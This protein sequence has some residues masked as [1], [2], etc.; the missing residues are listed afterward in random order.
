MIGS[1]ETWDPAR[2]LG[3]I[4]GD[5]GKAYRA[6]YKAFEEYQLRKK[7]ITMEIGQDVTFMSDGSNAINVQYDSRSAL[8]QF[9]FFRNFEKSI[10]ELANNHA[11]FEKWSSSNFEEAEQFELT[12]EKAEIEDWFSWERE[13][14]INKSQNPYEDYVTRNVE[15]RIRKAVTRKKYEVLFSFLERT[16]ERLQM[17]NKIIESESGA[18]FNTA[19]GNKFNKDV[20]AVFKKNEKKTENDA[21]SVYEFDRFADENFVGRTF[22][23]IPEPPDYFYD[24]VK[25]DRV[26]S[27]NLI[28]DTK[29]KIFADNIHLFDERRSRFPKSWEGFSDVECAANFGNMLEITQARVRRNFRAAVPFYYPGLRK[30]QMLLPVTFSPGTDQEETHALVVARVGAGY[31]IE[32]IMPLDWAYKNA[33]L[34][35]KPDREDWLDF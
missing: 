8:F 19:L 32:T 22:P 28:L 16:F 20:F 30:I 25:K 1:I 13:K 31:S 10:A 18:V 27:D 17:E 7:R 23:D 14:L 29:R 24:I 5:D 9:A 15:E 21:S 34:L 3:I 2:S 35:A 26:P 4:R 12:K 33:R 11:V 6:H